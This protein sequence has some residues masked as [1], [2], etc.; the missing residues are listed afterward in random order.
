MPISLFLAAVCF[1]AA[2]FSFGMLCGLRMAPR[3]RPLQPPALED[4]SNVINM[5]NHKKK[6]HTIDI[7]A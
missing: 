2:V 5:D 4:Y 3:F 7:I 1:I 6:E